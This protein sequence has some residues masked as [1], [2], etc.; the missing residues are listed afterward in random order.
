MRERIV[1][2][3]IAIAIGL[4]VT[5]L[6]YFLYQQT[7]SLPL[8]ASNNTQNGAP[9]PTPI[10]GVYLVVEEPKDESLTD[11][12]AIQVKGQTKPEYTVIISS[13]QEDVIIKPSNDGKFSATITIDTGTNRIIT[14]AIT[15]DGEESE[16]VKIVTYNTE[17]F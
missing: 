6:V 15:P 1:I 8:K 11:K 13:N 14:R 17:E 16:N 7:K 10:G 4:I 3:F 9:T 12:R 5:T 2:V